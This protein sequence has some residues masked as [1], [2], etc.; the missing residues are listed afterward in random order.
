MNYSIF[1]QNLVHKA[2][3]APPQDVGLIQSEEKSADLG[4]IGK[5]EGFGS[6]NSF[7][8]ST[9]VDPTSTITKIISNAIGVLTI[10]AGIWFL[11]QAILAGYN[12]LS[13]GGD[14][15]RIEAAGRKLTNAILGLVIVVAAYGI[16]A[17]IG[18]FL[19]TDFL[20]LGKF[21]NSISNTN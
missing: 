10:V 13:A 20:D 19:G 6:W 17:L 8:N 1:I 7:L 4:T 12:Y 21:F 15:T 11:F 5:G 3:A 14:K 9:T 2:Y 18:T 16:L